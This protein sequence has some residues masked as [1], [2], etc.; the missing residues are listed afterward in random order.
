MLLIIV[1]HKS[2]HVWCMML[3]STTDELTHVCTEHIW[4]IVSLSS[5]VRGKHLQRWNML[6]DLQP[7]ILYDMLPLVKAVNQSLRLCG[8]LFPLCLCFW[9]KR[10]DCRDKFFPSVWWKKEFVDVN[11]YAKQFNCQTDVFKLACKFIIKRLMLRFHDGQFLKMRSAELEDCYWNNVFTQHPSR[12]LSQRQCAI[13]P[14]R[15]DSQNGL[16]HWLS[17]GEKVKYILIFLLHTRDSHTL[18]RTCVES[19]GWV[20]PTEKVAGK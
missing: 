4:V 2:N 16:Q 14:S 12:T 5:C 20:D 13:R 6:T 15:S 18:H 9:L 8:F 10:T 11:I 17:V 7:L 1:L 3:T 19:I